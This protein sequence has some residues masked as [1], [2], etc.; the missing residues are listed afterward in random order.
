MDITTDGFGYM[1]IFG[2]LVWVPYTYSI[3]S[4]YLVDHDPYLSWYTLLCIVLV[5]IFGYCIFRGANGQKDTFRRNP[6]SSEVSH[7]TYLQTKRGTKLLT[8]GYWGLARKINYTGDWIMGLSWCMVCG[9]DSIVPY[10][11]LY[12]LP[13]YLY[14]VQYV[15]ITCVKRS[16][17]MIGIDIRN[18][19][20]IDLY[21]GLFK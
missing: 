7:L 18:L 16:M 14:I 9:F 8:S 3:Q 15:M 19:F 12:T 21:L 6:E 13:Y 2:D 20:H 11:M 1:L 5:N 17:V 10:Y 4:R